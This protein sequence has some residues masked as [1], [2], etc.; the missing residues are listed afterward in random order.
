VR[1]QRAEALFS[2]L[3]REIDQFVY[4]T[5][6]CVCVCVCIVQYYTVTGDHVVCPFWISCVWKRN[7]FRGPERLLIRMRLVKVPLNCAHMEDLWTIPPPPFL[8]NW[9]LCWEGR[10]VRKVLAWNLART[11]VILSRPVIGQTDVNWQQAV[12]FVKLW[13]RESLQH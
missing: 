5:Y 6:F 1:E 3:W 8:M 10:L 4:S 9:R 2:C 7:K 11:G 13:T 12:A